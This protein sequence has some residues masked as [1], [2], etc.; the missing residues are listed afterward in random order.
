MEFCGELRA[1]RLDCEETRW[2][3]AVTGIYTYTDLRGAQGHARRS[4][5]HA[6]CVGTA[7]DHEC[8]RRVK[9]ELAVCE[10]LSG[11]ATLFGHDRI[12]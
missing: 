9:N 11:S 1:E 4:G 3:V 12:W 7:H 5:R 10:S 2:Q 6:V 8:G